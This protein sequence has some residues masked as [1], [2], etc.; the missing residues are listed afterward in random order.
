M[1]SRVRLFVTPW[2]AALQASLSITNSRSLLKL[3]SIELVMRKGTPLASRVAQGV[4]GP[5]SSCV[6]N[7]R[8]SNSLQPHELQHTRLSYPSPTPGAH[9]NSCPL[10]QCQRAPVSFLSACFGCDGGGPGPAMS[11]GGG[12]SP[13]S[14]LH[15]DR[16][17]NFQKKLLQAM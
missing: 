13:T 9:S 4:S 3:M 12:C 16:D 17:V 1:L 11:H 14:L 15:T 7:L 2:T 8:V 6:W 10:S 5:S